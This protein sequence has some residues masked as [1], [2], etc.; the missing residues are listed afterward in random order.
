[1]WAFAQ[2]DSCEIDV[3]HHFEFDA[4][5]RILLIVM[6]GDVEGFE[7]EQMNQKMREQVV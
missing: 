6:E 3:P 4:K 1:V 2:P 7:I 5:H